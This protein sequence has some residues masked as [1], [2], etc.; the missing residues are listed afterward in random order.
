MMPL[1]RWLV[2]AGFWFPFAVATYAAFAPEGVPTPFHVSDVVL[3]AFTFTYLT[4]ALWFAYFATEAWWKSAGW[5]FSYGVLIE[6]IQA[7]EPM[8]DAELK[9]IAV[10]VVG[11]ALGLVLYRFVVV[12]WRVPPH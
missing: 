12:R 2:L 1:P 7:F 11:I 6:A 4:A 10:D 5:M 9:D 3:H 8:R